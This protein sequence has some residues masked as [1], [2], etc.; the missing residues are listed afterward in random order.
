MEEV[1]EIIALTDSDGALTEVGK[2]ELRLKIK[3]LETKVLSFPQVEI[4]PVHHFSKSVYAREITIPAGTLIVGAI[5]RHQNLNIIS[6]GDVTFFSIDGAKR[7]K[8]P[9]TFVASPGVK[10]VIFAHEDTVW[11]TIHGTDE[12]DVERIEDEFIAKDYEGL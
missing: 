12:T 9:H 10:R 7:A 1:K 3:D 8:A 5:H 6:K 2:A 11:T 4:P